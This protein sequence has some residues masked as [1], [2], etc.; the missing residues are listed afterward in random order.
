MAP[1]PYPH[2]WLRAKALPAPLNRAKWQNAPP[3]DVA[4]HA[5]GRR[6]ARRPGDVRRRRG[7][8]RPDGGAARFATAFAEIGV[9]GGESSPPTR[10]ISAPEE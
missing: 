8:D 4:E 3:P 6:G 5:P 10:S 2:Y 7:A 9:D 1:A